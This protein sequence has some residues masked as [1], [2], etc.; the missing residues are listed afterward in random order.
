VLRHVDKFSG[1]AGAAADDGGA[2]GARSS[3]GSP[4]GRS[5][6]AS[7]KDAEDSGAGGYQSRPRGST[8]AKRDMAEDTQASRMMKASTDALS[9]LAQATSERTTVAFFNSAA[10]RDTPEA[11]AFR[12]AHARKLMVAAALDVSPPGNLSSLA[13]TAADPTPAT[14]ADV[15]AEGGAT[16]STPA[17]SST[18]TPRTP[19][20]LASAQAPAAGAALGPASTPPA[21]IKGPEPPARSVTEAAASTSAPLASA[22]GSGA[23]SCGRRSL[24]TKQAK[25]AAALAAASKTLDNENDGVYV[26]PVFNTLDSGAGHVEN[27]DEAEGDDSSDDETNAEYQ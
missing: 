20:A 21:S 22:D 27:K 17:L 19:P 11:V 25:A 14:G 2:A 10:M 1:A 23:A 9:A 15:P 5:T 3:G 6:S 16:P 8:A 7:D 4:G 26:V 13:G 24:V 12:R 18:S